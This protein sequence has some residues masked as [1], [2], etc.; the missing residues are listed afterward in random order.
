MDCKSYRKC[1]WRSAVLAA[2]VL[3]TTGGDAAAADELSLPEAKLPGGTV[4]VV[5]CDDLAATSAA[6][7]ATQLGQLLCG[8]SFVPIRQAAEKRNVATPLHLRPWF[9]FDWKELSSHAGPAVLAAVPVDGGKVGLAWVFPTSK[10]PGEKLF[11]AGRAYFRQRADM[12][13]RPM[14]WARQNWPCLGL[15][16]EAAV[17][18]LPRILCRKQ[19]PWQ[20]AAGRPPWQSGN[21]LAV[22]QKIPWERSRILATLPAMG[23]RRDPVHRCAG[24][25]AA[26][27]VGGSAV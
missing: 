24:G 4:L 1:L 14:P 18:I 23:R 20:P 25:C 3:R 7:Q 10:R 15:R 27:T 5:A 11:D 2:W 26:G 8:E 12:K 6:W 16:Q 21:S 17:P 9:G 13:R 19:S 22:R